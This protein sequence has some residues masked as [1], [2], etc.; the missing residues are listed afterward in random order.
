M[1]QWWGQIDINKNAVEEMQVIS[2]AF[3]AEYGQAMSGIVNI[4]TK[5]GSDDFRGGM[6]FYGGDFLSS[7]NDIFLNINE[8][9]PITTKNIEGHLQ[10][11]IIP[12]KIFFYGN[13]RWIDFKGAYEGQRLYKPS[14]VVL[15]YFNEEGEPD[16]YILNYWKP[17][18]TLKEGIKDIIK[19]MNNG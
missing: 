8:F 12:G 4:V 19:E 11:S 5:D 10:G 9:N 13:A 1:G 2:G 18:I 7:N 15:S 17:K 16:T 14:S 3:N 6:T